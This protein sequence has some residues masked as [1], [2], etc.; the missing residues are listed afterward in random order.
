VDDPRITR[1]GKF[2][3][4]TRIDELPQLFNILHGEMSLVGPRPEML[5]N[6]ENY[7]KEM[8]EFAYR[9]RV[10]AGLTGTAQVNGKYNTPPREKLM[11]DISYIEDYSFWLDIK[12]MLKTVLVFFSDDSTEPFAKEDDDAK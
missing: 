10:K 1:V 6:I 4:R 2:L 3:R 9:T 8:P 12:L 11:M 5:E 7:M